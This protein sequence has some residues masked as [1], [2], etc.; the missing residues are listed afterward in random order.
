MNVTFNQLYREFKK[1][2]TFSMTKDQ[3]LLWLMR[4]QVD[5]PARWYVFKFDEGGHK[6]PNG[7][8]KIRCY[9]HTEVLLKYFR[10]YTKRLERKR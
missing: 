9:L 4:R 8:P 1:C 3:F 5:N 10:W 2:L 7:W 6:Y